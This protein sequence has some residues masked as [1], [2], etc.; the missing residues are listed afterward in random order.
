MNLRPGAAV[1]RQRFQHNH[2]KELIMKK[3]ASLFT[4]RWIHPLQLVALTLTLTVLPSYAQ[5]Q[6]VDDVRK[7]EEAAKE[8]AMIKARTGQT[9]AQLELG[10]PRK[11]EQD[12]RFI[13]YA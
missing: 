6:S 10:A 8:E 5:Y 12:D 11:R 2:N 1:P 9:G 7:Q 13:R 3:P 4:W